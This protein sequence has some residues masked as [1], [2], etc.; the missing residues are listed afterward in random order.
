MVLSSYLLKC[1]DRIIQLQSEEYP[2]EEVSEL[3]AYMAKWIIRK[4][5]VNSA[6]GLFLYCASLNLLNTWVKQDGVK[7]NYWFKSKVENVAI[8]TRKYNFPDVFIDYQMKMPNDKYGL[9]IFQLGPLQF[10]F[11]NVRRSLLI[12]DIL[13][14]PIARE[15]E[16][17]GV[18]KQKC[19]ATIFYM[20][21]KGMEK[22][23]PVEGWDAFRRRYQLEESN[24]TRSSIHDGGI[25]SEYE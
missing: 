5:R 22:F 7:R 8:I 14:S 4:Y 3:D 12:D 1:Q 17:D 11:H 15:I 10:S 2:K 19:A 20:A 9:M 18:R 23:P 13:S 21:L 24:H 25:S 16:W 6:S